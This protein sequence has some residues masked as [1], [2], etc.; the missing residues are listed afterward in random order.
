MS[1]RY[2][3][4]GEFENRAVNALH[5]EG[6]GHAPLEDDW[7]GRSSGTASGGCARGTATSWSGS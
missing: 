6:F 4:R 7:K 5:A 3:W 2:E 1:V